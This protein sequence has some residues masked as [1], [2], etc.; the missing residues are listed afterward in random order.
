MELF[1]S[2]VFHIAKW[3]LY[4]LKFSWKNISI[5]GDRHSVDF[6]SKNQQVFCVFFRDNFTVGFEP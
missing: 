5:S 2:R 4:F 6:Q 3:P 1:G